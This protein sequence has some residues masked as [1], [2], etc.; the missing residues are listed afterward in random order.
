MFNGLQYTF[1]ERIICKKSFLST[2]LNIRR[3]PKYN[4]LVIIR[5]HNYTIK[6]QIAINNMFMYKKI[7]K[8]LL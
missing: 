1:N 7:R 5:R 6:M 4:S 8:Q 3:N 2:Y